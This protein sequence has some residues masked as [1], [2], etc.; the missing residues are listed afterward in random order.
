MLFT[1]FSSEKY[2][3]T[4]EIFIIFANTRFQ[5]AKV[6][7]A[8]ANFDQGKGFDFEGIF[9]DT[10]EYIEHTEEII[11]VYFFA[12]H[13]HIALMAVQTQNRQIIAITIK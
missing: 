12:V 1:C 8:V 5:M 6:M 4:L 7:S 11:W 3:I 10:R 9:G 13:Q 2:P